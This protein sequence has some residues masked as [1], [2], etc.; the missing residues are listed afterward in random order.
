MEFPAKTAALVLLAC[1]AVL[2]AA[3]GQEPGM[4][5]EA[6]R[7]IHRDAALQRR[8]SRARTVTRSEGREIVRVALNSSRLPRYDCSHFVH[9]TYERAGFPYTYA[10][11][12]ELYEG[13]TR[14]SCGWRIRSRATWQCGRDMRV[15][16]S[17]PGGILF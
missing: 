15:L 3:S 1:A 5:D 8:V 2:P 16:W 17:I 9:G 4:A 7:G 12:T 11:S 13:E 14:N 6:G 10:S